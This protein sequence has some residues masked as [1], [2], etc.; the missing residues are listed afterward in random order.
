MAKVIN[1]ALYRHGGCSGYT[2]YRYG[3]QGK[4][5]PLAAVSIQKPKSGAEVKPV[6][7]GENKRR[8]INEV[9]DALSDWRKSPFE[10]EGAMRAGLRSAMCLKGHAWAVSDWQAAELVNAAFTEMGAKRPSWEEGERGYALSLDY[11]AWCFCA[12]AEEDRSNGRRFCS[13][14]CA[15]VSLVHMTR[16]EGGR[17]TATIRN[18][19]RLIEQDKA[20]PRDCE[21]CGKSFKSDA[22]GQRFCTGSCAALHRLGDSVLR[23]RE[24]KFC[25][26]TFMPSRGK[27][28]YC[29]IRCS[30]HANAKASADA[31]AHVTII[32]GC[33]GVAFHP[34][35]EKT[36]YCTPKCQT[37]MGIRA[38][39]ARKRAENAPRRTSCEHC[40]DDFLPSRNGQRFCSDACVFD[41]KRY[42]AGAKPRKMTRRVFDHFIGM[43]FDKAWN[44][45]LTPQRFDWM[46]MEKG[47]AITME[48]AA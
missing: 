21:Y 29:T 15:R 42:R 22:K 26:A 31:L 7:R 39:K 27:Q 38:W 19:Y 28:Q 37:E 41:A 1:N 48:V 30:R 14:E 6:Y 33:C 17:Y 45:R 10:N 35:T 4:A 36:R 32:C 44:S 43:H 12:I 24:C 40:G 5:L 8:L 11:C 46:L 9:M 23:E 16:K 47:A 2:E 34:K 25:H 18:A 3:D 20:A 13:V